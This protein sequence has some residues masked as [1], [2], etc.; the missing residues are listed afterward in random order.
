MDKYKKLNDFRNYLKTNKYVYVYENI[1]NGY[2]EI[3]MSYNNHKSKIELEYN[4]I[5]C[6]NSGTIL[7]KNVIKR[8]CDILS[9][10]IVSVILKG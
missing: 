4:D 10:D 2:M 1:Q 7:A 8:L 6:C 3:Y 5:F 9:V